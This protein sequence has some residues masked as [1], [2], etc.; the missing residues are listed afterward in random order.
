MESCVGFYTDPER[1]WERQFASWKDYINYIVLCAKGDE[2]WKLVPSDVRTR[3][4]SF[5]EEGYKTQAHTGPWH[6]V[7][8]AK[9]R[10]LRLK[11]SAEHEP[12]KGALSSQL[13]SL[14]WTTK[15]LLIVPNSW[16]VTYDM[17]LEKNEETT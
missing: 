2:I 3:V 8:D 11:R 7:K 9:K 10:Y 6:L 4:D 14:L 13:R 16:N 1:E 17:V 15:R 12:F 5:L